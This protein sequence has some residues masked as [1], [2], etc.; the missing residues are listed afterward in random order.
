MNNPKIHVYLMCRNRID[1]AKECIY[2]IKKQ[3]YINYE[4]TVSDNSTNSFLYKS[5]LEVFPDINIKRR[6]PPLSA[7]EHQNIILDEIESDYFVVFHDDDLMMPNYLSRMV[8]L[9]IEY[10]QCS[11]IAPNGIIIKDNI[12][13]KRAFAKKLTSVVYHENGESIFDHYM[14][15]KKNFHAPFPGYMYQSKFTLKIRYNVEEGGIY[16]DVAFL[17][18]LSN[19]APVLWVPDKLIYYRD[20]HAAGRYVFDFKGKLS[21]TRF[22]QKF[23]K[24]H[25]SHKNVIQF[26]LNYY[27]KYLRLY[28]IN[29]V[30]TKRTRRIR[31]LSMFIA[32]IFIKR[33]IYLFR[34]LILK[35]NFFY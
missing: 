33:P 2:S 10:P 22:V 14:S 28:G 26:K 9:L 32:I 35:T 6:L 8:E 11:A 23:S 30:K 29:L 25:K 5:L 4:L 12:Y 16:N 31:I 27:I 18:K 20:H 1:Y 13:T 24:F 34:L 19:N 15:F 21:L 17:M 3:E 7:I